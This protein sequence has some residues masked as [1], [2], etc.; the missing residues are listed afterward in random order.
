MLNM[1]QVIRDVHKFVPD[2]WGVILVSEDGLPIDHAFTKAIGVD[3]PLIISGLLSSATGLIENL[4]RELAESSMELLFSQGD[5]LSILIGR[6]DVG[7]LAFVASP[8]AKLGPML[9]EFKKQAKTISDAYR[10]VL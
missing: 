5:K 4:L 3:D 10:E 6:V 9:M 8:N 2:V 1:E 7:F